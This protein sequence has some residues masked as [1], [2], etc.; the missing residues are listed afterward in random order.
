MADLAV[1]PSAPGSSAD[2]TPDLLVL[3]ADPIEPN[4]ARVSILRR[5]SSWDRVAVHDIELGES[6]LDARWLIAL[7]DRHYALIATSA[8]TATGDGHAVVV[9]VEV[10]D[11]GGS[12]TLVESGR[13]TIDRAVEDAG[14]PT[15]TGSAALSSSSVCDPGTTRRA[16]AGPRPSTSSTRP[17]WPSGGRS[18]VPGS[19]DMASSD[20]STPCPA[21]TSLWVPLPTARRAVKA[22]PGWS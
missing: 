10:R 7:G 20:A 17:T 22:D 14:P 13:S 15:S 6:D 2:T 19:W 1:I 16:R 5:A 12:P 3:D 21:T 9:G 4:Q 18:S 11:E 8:T